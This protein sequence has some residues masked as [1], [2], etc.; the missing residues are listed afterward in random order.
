VSRSLKNKIEA[1]LHY[2]IEDQSVFERLL[3][4]HFAGN[5]VGLMS[6]LSWV[7]SVDQRYIE[8]LRKKYGNYTVDL[9]LHGAARL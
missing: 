8:K 3:A 9:F 1:L 2:F 5:P 6:M 4:Q 7:Q